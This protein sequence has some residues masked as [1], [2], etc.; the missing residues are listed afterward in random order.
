M[1]GISVDGQESKAV[2]CYHDQLPQ[3]CSNQSR[4]DMLASIIEAEHIRRTL[5]QRSE[6]LSVE[7]ED[8]I[9]RE[10]TDDSSRLASVKWLQK[11][12]QNFK[13]I[14]QMTIEAANILE[15]R[16]GENGGIYIA[17]SKLTESEFNQTHSSLKRSANQQLLYAPV[18][19]H[20][21]GSH[22]NDRDSGNKFQSAPFTKHRRGARNYTQD[23]ICSCD[24]VSNLS[25]TAD[26]INE[27]IDRSLLPHSKADM[28][29]TD[30]AR[31]KSPK[32]FWKRILKH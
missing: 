13:D 8:L 4:Q 28:T 30:R 23:S 19:D 1:S 14:G 2:P 16:A 6:G 18:E 12:G 9:K 15:K 17:L 3:Y 24:R 21:S 10:P 7:T 31:A 20:Q 22:C 27:K 11:C 29:R 5:E 25:T 26:Y 32:S